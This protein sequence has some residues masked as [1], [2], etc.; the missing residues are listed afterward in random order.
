MEDNN[1]LSYFFLGLGLGVAVGVL[2]AP[3]APPA[4]MALVLYKSFFMSM[5]A[6]CVVAAKTCGLRAFA[7]S[8]PFA[9]SINKA[10]RCLSGN[11]ATSCS[12]S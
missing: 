9:K 11:L 7:V 12:T 5:E 2:F 4:M 6:P 3:K 10:F 1:K 8:M